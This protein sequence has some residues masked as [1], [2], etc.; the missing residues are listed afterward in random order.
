MSRSLSLIGLKDEAREWLEKQLDQKKECC[1]TCG[2]KLATGFQPTIYDRED[3]WYGTELEL[4]EFV[5][6]N[7]KVIREVIQE[8][9]WSSGPVVFM[10]LEDQKGKQLFPW[11]K[12]EMEERL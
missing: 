4:R 3:V 9:P 10:C 5:T 2:A 11:S 6:K 12:E 8:I 1:P 7:G